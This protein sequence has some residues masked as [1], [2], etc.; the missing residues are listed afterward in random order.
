MQELI[1][2]LLTHSR[3]GA[4]NRPLEPVDCNSVVSKAL[5]NLSVAIHEGDVE[6]DVGELP[7]VVANRVELIQLFQNL[8]GNAVKY[9]SRNNPRVEVRMECQ[10]GG[11][12][13][14]VKDNGI[15]IPEKDRDRVFEAFQRLHGDDQYPGT[16]IGLATCKKIVEHLDGKIWVES[17]EG[18]GCEFLFI[19]PAHR[20][21][22]TRLRHFSGFSS[23]AVR[24]VKSA[25]RPETRSRRLL[26]FV[27]LQ[28][29]EPEHV[30]LL[31]RSLAPTIS[32][33]SRLAP[34][35]RSKVPRFRAS[36]ATPLL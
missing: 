12:L 7:T 11:W 18:E 22:V 13:F 33:S 23:W 27:Q 5:S 16:G 1:E 8:I 20:Q 28:V 24:P 32:T 15:G 17:H 34:R 31:A 21:D 30:P 4:A 26:D 25:S 3:V 14:R 10:E 6:I 9:R 19:L 2:D 35:V 29:V 36:V